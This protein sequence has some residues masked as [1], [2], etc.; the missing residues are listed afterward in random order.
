ME[1]HIDIVLSGFLERYIK[2]KKV[3]YIS[4][5]NVD[6]YLEEKGAAE[7]NK[8]L[9]SPQHKF[10]SVKP[11]TKFYK[12]VES[13]EKEINRMD[14]TGWVCL[15]GAGVAGNHLGILMRSQGGM[16]IDI[17]SVFDLWA[18]KDSR[19]WIKKYKPFNN[20][21]TTEKL[22]TWL[23][24]KNRDY[25][26]GIQ[27]FIDLN[28]D[29][30]KVPFLQSGS[31]KIQRTILTRQLD[32]YARVKNIKP[33]IF[34]E[35][36]PATTARKKLKS[37]QMPKAVSKKTAEPLYQRPLI[38]TNPSVKFDELPA[39]L[40][41]LFKENSRLRGEM[42]TLHAELK[43]IQDDP[44]KE[45]RRRELARGITDRQKTARANW[46]AI[47]KWW[48]S[49]ND[50]KPSGKSPEEKAAEEALKRDKRIKA[51]LNYLRRYK[52]TGKEKQK[53]EIAKRKKELDE[54]GVSY[55]ELVR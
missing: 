26:T 33:R 11:E 22:A 55:E 34:K 16:V 53:N 2:G 21:K 44:Q 15:L 47:D 32:H 17:G 42:K 25:K 12:E 14:L 40:Q 7:I 48:N 54:W 46:E 3:F 13:V 37:Q 35:K 41:E 8:I 4:C 10:E 43:N 51:N 6:K 19:G 49:R 5:R 28:I 23:A 30:K 1:I 29:V 50:E 20:M 52:N 18:G 24:T 38:D 39:N 36:S 9:I 31:G 45:E 27:L